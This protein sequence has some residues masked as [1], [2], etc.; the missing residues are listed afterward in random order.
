MNRLYFFHP[1]QG[2]QPGDPRH[3]SP[4][5]EVLYHRNTILSLFPV[6]EGEDTAIVGVLPLGK[7]IRQPKALFGYAG[8]VYFAVYVSQDYELLERPSYLEVTCRNMPGGVVIEALS[9][10]QAAEL[11]IYGLE[12]FAAAAMKRAPEF[13][14]GESLSAVYT[15]WSG[16]EHL[17]LSLDNKHLGILSQINGKPVSFEHYKV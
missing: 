5:M 16:N 14:E 8:N 11:G 4:Y 6:P 10:D 3:Q 15:A 9:T 17:Q 2:Y 7:W 1:G 12:E 13:T